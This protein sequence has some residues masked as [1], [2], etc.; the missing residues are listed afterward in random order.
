MQQRE[1]LQPFNRPARENAELVARRRNDLVGP[2][3][4]AG[5]TARRASNTRVRR[6]KNC[7]PGSRESSAALSCFSALSTSSAA[8]LDSI[9]ERASANAL[10]QAA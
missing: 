9:A 2:L 10:E 5:L 8:R 3:V 1:L 7:A 4:L 6:S